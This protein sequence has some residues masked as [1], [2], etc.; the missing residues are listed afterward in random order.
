MCGVPGGASGKKKTLLPMQ[1]TPKTRVQCL[2]QEDLLEW[3]MATHSS[4][5]AWKIPWTKEPDGCI[6]GVNNRV[7]HNIGTEKRKQNSSLIC[8][9]N[10]VDF[11]SN[12]QIIF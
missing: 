4:I 11:I 9:E 2:G 5:L 1:E 8:I 7:G 6:H 12:I 3:E 10:Q